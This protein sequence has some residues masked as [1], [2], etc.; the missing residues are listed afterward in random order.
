MQDLPMV[1][2]L[3]R[4]GETLNIV[5]LEGS[6]SIRQQLLSLGFVKGHHLQ[7]VQRTPEGGLV[8]ALGED[9]VGLSSEMVQ[10]IQVVALPLA[11]P[12][13]PDPS[14]HQ[15]KDQ[16]MS[17]QTELAQLKIGTRARVVGYAPAARPYRQKLLAMG[18]TP[19]TEFIVKRHAPLGD[20]VDIEVRGVHLSL[21]KVEAAVITVEEVSHA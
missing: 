6:R 12:H 10:A 13:T 19:G 2:G 21:R 7:I 11:S 20:P 3:A 15:E 1:L 8:V 5:G 16:T 4:R 17:I 9:R 14:C 18:L